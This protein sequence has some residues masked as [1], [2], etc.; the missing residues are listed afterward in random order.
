M[1]QIWFLYD[2][3]QPTYGKPAYRL[4]VTECI[5]KL[6]V[7][8]SRFCSDLSRLP[9]FNV[10]NTLGSLR[11]FR[12]SVMKLNEDEAAAF[13]WK[14]GYYRLELKPHEVMERLGRP[15]ESRKAS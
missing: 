5:D 7:F 14:A 2:G 15:E 4:P 9:K 13:G 8:R 6:D 10:A 11:G 3:P 1:A 12:H